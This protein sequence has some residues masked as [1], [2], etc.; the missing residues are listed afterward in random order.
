MYYRDQ[1]PARPKV[2]RSKRFA[3]LGK[4][5]QRHE[6]RVTLLRSIVTWTI[7]R[8]C[9]HCGAEQAS[10]MLDD[11]HVMAY[12]NLERI[13]PKGGIYRVSYSSKKLEQYRKGSK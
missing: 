2:S 8:T 10:P 13:P 12:L 1:C 6:F 11:F 3:L 5:S 4:V 7:L 9:K